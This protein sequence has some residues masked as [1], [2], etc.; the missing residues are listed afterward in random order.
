MKITNLQKSFKIKENKKF[1]KNLIKVLA[2]LWEL[3]YINSCVC[4]VK[5]S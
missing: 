5:A 2:F 1:L 4:A 3:C